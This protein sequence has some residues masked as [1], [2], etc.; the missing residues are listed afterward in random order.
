MK[1]KIIA[2]TIAVL[3]PPASVAFLGLL[4]EYLQLRIIIGTLLWFALMFSLYKFVKLILDD[5]DVDK[6]RKGNRP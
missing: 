3:F 6:R 5:R 1:N 4:N 2:G